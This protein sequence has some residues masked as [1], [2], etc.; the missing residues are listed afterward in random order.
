MKVSGFDTSTTSHEKYSEKALLR[1]R[2]SATCE[3]VQL[4]LGVDLPL[5]Y[6]VNANEKAVNGGV[7]YRRPAWSFAPDCNRKH[8]AGKYCT[9]AL[10]FIL[11]R[12]RRGHATCLRPADGKAGRQRT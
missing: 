10:E 1:H 3:T 6:V 4:D 2:Y 5:E 12:P 7:A 9:V 11:D 8:L